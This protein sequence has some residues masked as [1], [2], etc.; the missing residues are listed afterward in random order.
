MTHLSECRL[1]AIEYD[2]PVYINRDLEY[3]GGANAKI[4]EEAEQEMKDRAVTGRPSNGG[5]R[6]LMDYQKVRAGNE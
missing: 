6:F 3:M 1:C 4:K 5:I 2:S